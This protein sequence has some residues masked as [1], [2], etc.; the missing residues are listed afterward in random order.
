MGDTEELKRRMKEHLTAEERFLLTR[1]ALRCALA[2]QSTEQ[3]RY[4]EMMDIANRLGF[5]DLGSQ[6]L[7]WGLEQTWKERAQ[8]PSDDDDYNV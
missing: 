4:D 5:G 6:L 7:E 1:S 8:R 3:K 2:D